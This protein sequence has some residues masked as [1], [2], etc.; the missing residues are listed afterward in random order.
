MEGGKMTKFN[1]KIFTATDGTQVHFITRT[2]GKLISEDEMM[3]YAKEVGLVTTPEEAEKDWKPASP[4]MFLIDLRSG[5]AFC[6]A[7]Y[8]VSESTVERYI[9]EM[10]PHINASFYNRPVGGQRQG[11]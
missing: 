5:L 4:K 7:K 10:A 8:G 9:K 6:S 2:R 11:G 1:A 3:E